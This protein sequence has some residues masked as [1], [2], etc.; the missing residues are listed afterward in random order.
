[1]GVILMSFLFSSSLGA[2]T[3]VVCAM[4]LRSKYPEI[5]LKP[6]GIHVYAFGAPP[7]L[8]HD[9]AIAARM[10]CTTIVNN[11][12]LI[13]R[14]NISNLVTSLMCL[15]KI[16]EKLSELEMCPIGPVSSV[17]FLNKLAEGISGDSLI[18]PSEL[19][20]TILDAHS[21]LTLRHPQHLFLPGRVLLVYESWL[22]E[23][24]ESNSIGERRTFQC[25]QTA[26]TSAV[27]QRLE[28][29]G[30]R[31]LTDHLTSSYFEIL[32]I[33]YEF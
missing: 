3:A 9:T 19:E 28:I 25:V 30:L 32:G 31:C 13:S 23:R 15:R 2:G 1:M 27:F 12:D 4:L 26:G 18:T 8:D 22:N 10:Y 17:K 11:S 7:V 21:D 33:D 20:Q 5:F 29:D 24:E 16:Q 6:K 14:L